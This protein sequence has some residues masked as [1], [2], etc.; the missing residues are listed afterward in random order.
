MSDVNM[1]EAPGAHE[2]P[3]ASPREPTTPKRPPKRPRPETPRKAIQAPPTPKNWHPDQDTPPASPS[4]EAPQSQLGLELQSH[5]AAAVASRTAQLKTT[6]DEVL[7]LVSVISQKVAKWEEKS[8]QGAASLGKDIR[9]LVLNFS[10]NLATAHPAKQ[11][12]HQPPHPKHNSYAEATRTPPNAPKT[13][14][15]I[16]KTT[17]KSPQSEKTPRIFLRLPKDHPA[18]RASPY[19]TM[20]ILRKHLDRTCSAAVK[21]VQQVPSGLAIWPKDGLGFQLLM[22][23]KEALEV[24]LQGAKAEVEQ[25]WAIFALP[26]A[27]QEYTSYD[28]TQ[29][30]ITEH[31][32]LEEFK[33]QTGLSPLKFYRSTKNPLSGTLIMAVPDTQAQ[34]VP[35]WVHLFGKNVQIKR[36]PFR[37]RIEQCTQCWDYHNPWTCTRTPRCRICSKKDHTEEAHSSPNEE[38]TSDPCCTN[39]CGPFPAD[40]SNCPTKP[41]IQ[42]G[43]IQRLTRSQFIAVRK[44]GAHQ[45]M[46][47]DQTATSEPSRNLG[48]SPTREQPQTC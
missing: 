15:K 30:P 7:E 42:Q 2:T 36:K 13:Q 4:Y 28:R 14:L 39:C 23:R 17:H 43:V 16:P 44:A 25:N 31:M 21:E 22:E 41:T 33:L 37:T 9:T 34:I 19:A 26:N 12:N 18:R 27:P 48:S 5:I 40:H 24:L 8:L 20:D 6:G 10:R 29:V 1:G 45:H 3:T 47:Q 35:K 46:L 38:E 11:E 32:A